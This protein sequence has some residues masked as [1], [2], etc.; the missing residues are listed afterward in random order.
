[1]ASANVNSFSNMGIPSIRSIEFIGIDIVVCPRDG[2][3][4]AK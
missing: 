3:D 4:V 2:D 1:M